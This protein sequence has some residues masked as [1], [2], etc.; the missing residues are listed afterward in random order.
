M[1]TE[2]ECLRGR[3]GVPIKSPKLAGARDNKEDLRRLPSDTD[4]YTAFSTAIFATG[5]LLSV[6]LNTSSA[7]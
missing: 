2:F 6:D 1:F 3:F 4:E 7:G 5:K